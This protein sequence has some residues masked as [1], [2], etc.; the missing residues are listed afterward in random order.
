MKRRSKCGREKLVIFHIEFV[1]PTLAVQG[2]LLLTTLP[3]FDPPA[4]LFSS[5]T[6]LNC[7]IEL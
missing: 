2:V 3:V 6:E 1:Y 5:G 4:Y 7:G